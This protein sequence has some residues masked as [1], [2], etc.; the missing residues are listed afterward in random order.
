M[1]RFLTQQ[2]LDEDLANY[3]KEA[4]LRKTDEFKQQV[5]ELY[6]AENFLPGDDRIN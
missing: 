3:K 1:S 4:E 6:K 5:K 2:E